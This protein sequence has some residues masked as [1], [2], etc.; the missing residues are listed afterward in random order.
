MNERGD[1]GGSG[2]VAKQFGVPRG[3]GI[4]SSSVRRRFALNEV[5][6]AGGDVSYG[7]VFWRRCMNLKI[8]NAL[9]GQSRLFLF[10]SAFE[11]I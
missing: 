7:G 4:K 10:W 6:K 11:N 1:G 2:C 3:E 5:R 9:G 8:E